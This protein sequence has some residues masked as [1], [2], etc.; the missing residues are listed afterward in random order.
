MLANM[1]LE[2][3]FTAGSREQAIALGERALVGGRLSDE[4]AVT[5][6]PYAV[7]SFTASGHAGRSLPVWDDAMAWQRAR[8]DVRRFALASAFRGD[9]A[10]D[11][12]DLDAAVADMMA[13]LELARNVPLPVLAELATAWL[14]YALV[15]AGEEGDE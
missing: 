14:A 3:V 9:A 8:G 5:C 15:D 7:I 12:G 13:A 4:D 6:V 2:E 10:L 1:A 11:V